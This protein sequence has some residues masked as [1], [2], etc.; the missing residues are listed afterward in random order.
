[1]TIRTRSD[2]DGYLVD[3][4]VQGHRVKRMCPD[5]ESAKRTEKALQTADREGGW[6]LGLH[7][8]LLDYTAHLR[9]RSKRASVEQAEVHSELLRRHFGREFNV[10]QMGQRDL[11]GFISAREATGKKAATINGS[12]RVLRAA[13][14]FAVEEGHLKKAP[15]KVKMLRE[16]RSLPTILSLED[17]DRLVAV[18]TPPAPL[19][20][21]LAGHAGLRHTEIR[22][23]KAHDVRL[24]EGEIRVTPKPEVGW[25]PKS[26]YERAIPL[27]R[28][29]R[30]A[31]EYTAD[32]HRQQW[33]FPSSVQYS[34][35]P[36]VTLN[37]AVRETFEKAGLYDRSRKTGLHM[38]RRTFASTLLANGA[39]LKTV[40]E[41]GGWSSLE[42]V[43]RYLASTDELKRGAIAGAFDNGQDDEEEDE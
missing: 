8:L 22:H 39:D 34:G 20:I 43:Q 5:M 2:R 42:V 4:W 41:L 32:L 40:M 33:L 6:W 1:V 31:L 14:N 25:T 3:V 23:T 36:I 16:A 38:L 30:R 10:S 24:R 17:V 12:L 11:D 7:D 9:A 26:Y 18:G 21:L 19:A 15:L 27:S 28:P 37:T 35:M 29:L 13:I